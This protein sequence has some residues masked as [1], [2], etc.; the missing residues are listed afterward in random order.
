V[1][2]AGLGDIDA[3]F[4]RLEVLYRGGR[5]RWKRGPAETSGSAQPGPGASWAYNVAVSI[6][7]EGET[8]ARLE[9]YFRANP[10]GIAAAYLFGSVAQGGARDASDVDVAVLLERVPPAT[11]DGL[12][13]DLADAL[14]EFLGRRVDLVILNRA[15]VD[16]AHRVLRDG[17]LVCDADPSARIG[18]E[19]RTRN[20]FFDL[21]PYLRQ[22][23]RAG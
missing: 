15:P 20:E 4:E 13:T 23:R 3:A 21:E 7:R 5:Q 14:Q 12:R 19:V 18:F 16:L 9:E 6:P 17:I 8:A 22:Y 2:H 11:L 10:E 1:I